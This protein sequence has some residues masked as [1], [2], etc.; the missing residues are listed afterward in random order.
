MQVRFLVLLAG[1]PA[2]ARLRDPDA[3]L[4]PDA[5]GAGDPELEL[6]TKAVHLL[7]LLEYGV[8][9][10]PVLNRGRALPRQPLLRLTPVLA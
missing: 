9:P 3:E 6:G 10:W 5:L 2:G 7:Y 4:V 8:E 1:V